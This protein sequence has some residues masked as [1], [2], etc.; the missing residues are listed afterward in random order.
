MCEVGKYDTVLL[1][2]GVTSAHLVVGVR[3]EQGA[4][5]GWGHKEART[6]HGQAL[7]QAVSDLGI[8]AKEVMQPAHSLT[9]SMEKPVCKP[10]V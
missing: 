2:P 3:W 4:L 10:T 1:P 5:S 6:S 7:L 8:E 9:V